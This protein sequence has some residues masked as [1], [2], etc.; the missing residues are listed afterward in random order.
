MTPQRRLIL[1]LLEDANT[2]LDAEAVYQRAREF[3]QYASLATVYRTLNL[4]MRVG[5][6]EQRFL[7]QERTRSYYEITGG[8]HYHF[9]CLDCGKVIEFETSLV[10][11]I[12]AELREKY[13]LVVQRA[14]IHFE[15]TC[16]DCNDCPNIDGE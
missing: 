15:G 2:H 3:D 14:R 13:G 11:Q 7:D 10:D 4:L 8:E 5:I 9:T 12:K 16:L 6:I 1:E